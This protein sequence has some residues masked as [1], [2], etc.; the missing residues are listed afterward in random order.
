MAMQ[1]G[2]DL[3]R[4]G[5]LSEAAQ[6]FQ[7]LA[8]QATAKGETR[9]RALALIA[10]AGCEIRLF[11]Y[12]SA[13]EHSKEARE[14]ALKADDL[15]LS[16]AA[17]GN[18]STIYSQLGDFEGAAQL[19]D[20]SV[21]LLRRSSNKGY[22]SNSL[23][24]EGDARFG[25]GKDAEGR[26]AFEQAI[27]VATRAK[28]PEVE[29]TA[30]DALGIWL[31]IRGNL[32]DGETY[33]N[34]A[35]RLRQGAHDM[36]GLAKS[37]EHLAELEWKKGTL[38]L[39]SARDHIDKAFSLSSQDFKT[40]P[41]YYPIHIRAKILRDLGDR[42]AALTEF[43]RAV[44]AA[45]VWRQSALPGDTTNTRTVGMLHETYHDYAELA[46]EE[47]L[48]RSDPALARGAWEV[49]ARNR[50]ASLREQLTRA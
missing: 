45:E 19:A 39:Q 29:A 12:S 46:A 27:E 8:R 5:R 37:H 36:D 38:F 31:V 40:S 48:R 10:L 4:A 21:A 6:S 42:Q 9:H 50:A 28:L 16:G 22:F 11:R 20:E 2:R 35:F 1:E 24:N 43:R 23:C 15:M 34:Q 33:L 3:R 25:V 41:Q 49:L 17:A 26:L 14:A 44:G 30:A 13:L 47:S 18:I 32:N 7:T